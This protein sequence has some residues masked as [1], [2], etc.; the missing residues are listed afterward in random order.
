MRRKHSL[1][2]R[3]RLPR[4]ALLFAAALVSPASAQSVVEYLQPQ[5]VTVAEALTLTGSVSTPL[6]AALSP[7]ISGLVDSVDVDAGD[8]VERGQR[9]LQL[10]ATLAR[11]ALRS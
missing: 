6:H 7:R 1:P 11:L 9:L 4:I 2:R 10:D 8:R 3:L 5:P